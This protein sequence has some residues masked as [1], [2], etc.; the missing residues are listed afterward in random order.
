MRTIIIEVR[1]GVIVHAYKAELPRDLASELMVV[2]LDG[3]K[4][5]EILL[6]PLPVNPLYRA[7]KDTQFAI[8][9]LRQR[10]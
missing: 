2:D 5:G 7:G 4:D 1:K 6:K 10:I 3:G 8:K 9:K